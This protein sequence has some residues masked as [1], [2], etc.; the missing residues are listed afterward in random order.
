MT[1]VLLSIVFI[2][3]YI[4]TAYKIDP[5]WKNVAE[6]IP[7]AWDIDHDIRWL[8]Q[9]TLNLPLTSNGEMVGPSL[10]YSTAWTHEAWNLLMTHPWGTEI[11]FNTFARLVQE[12]HGKT[13]NTGHSHNGWLDLGLNLGFPGLVLW[14]AFLSLIAYIGWSAWRRHND[15]LGLALLLLVILF[16]SRGTVDSIFQDHMI[17][18]FMLAAGLLLGTITLS[19]NNPIKTQAP[20]RRSNENNDKNA[21]S[22]D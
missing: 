2:S 22:Y 16:A 7:I 18:Q 4:V 5:R 20:P 11:S 17:E 21:H 13:A 3:G 8:N 19:K 15:S 9:N 12:K 14:T 6:T 10:Y 1:I